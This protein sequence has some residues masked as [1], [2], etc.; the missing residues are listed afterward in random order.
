MDGRC[1]FCKLAENKDKIIYENDNFYSILDLNQKVSGHAL[2]I[3]KK[4][5]ENILDMPNS[6]GAEALDCIKKQQLK[7]LNS[8]KQTDLI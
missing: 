1:I 3:S 2:I 7:L 6:L 5:F 8:K 4:H